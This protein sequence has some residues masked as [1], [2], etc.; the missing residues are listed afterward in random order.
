[1]VAVEVER[2]PHIFRLGLIEKIGDSLGTVRREDGLLIGDGIARAED[3]A[4]G[5]A[6]VAHI[7]ASITISHVH[8]DENDRAE[9]F[10][11]ADLGAFAHLRVGHKGYQAV[12]LRDRG[13]QQFV[14]IVEGVDADEGDLCHEGV[15]Y[16]VSSVSFK[17]ALIAISWDSPLQWF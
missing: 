13:I 1:M 14:G 12:L 10:A 17:H 9:G 11:N 7:H 3:T 15:H 16:R 4:G 6:E 8:L 2:E 5:L